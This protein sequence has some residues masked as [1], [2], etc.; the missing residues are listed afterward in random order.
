MISLVQ[1]SAYL[2]EN[3]KFLINF[4]RY[5]DYLFHWK[6]KFTISKFLEDIEILEDVKWVLMVNKREIRESISK[7]FSGEIGFEKNAISA[8]DRICKMI[9][10]LLNE[11]VYY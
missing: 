9:S 3:T 7:G 2:Q 6:R 5:V 4:S 8:V 11:Q 10:R 1:F